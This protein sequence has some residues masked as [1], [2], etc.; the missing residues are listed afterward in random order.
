[1]DE[2]EEHVL[3]PFTPEIPPHTNGNGSRTRRRR[4]AFPAITFGAL[5]GV[6]AAGSLVPRLQWLNLARVGWW[7][8][9]VISAAIAGVMT[10]AFRR[11]E[12]RFAIASGAV[13]GLVTL[14][15]VYAI[16]RASV[17]VLFVERS[18]A[19]TVAGDLLRLFLEGAPAGA[20]GAA[21][22]WSVRAFAIRA[23]ARRAGA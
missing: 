19:R 2:P 18:F 21:V 4:R 14:W 12:R 6:L 10:G 16:V 23:R 1:M 13:A 20:F 3:V 22:A 8:R 17:P 7:G 15:L 9:P 11:E 5:L